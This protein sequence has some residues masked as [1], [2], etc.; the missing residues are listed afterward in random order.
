MLTSP[1]VATDQLLHV[2]GLTFPCSVGMWGCFVLHDAPNAGHAA[3]TRV[4]LMSLSPR[5]EAW[6]QVATCPPCS[7]PHISSDL[8]GP[9]GVT[10]IP[11]QTL[12]DTPVWPALDKGDKTNEVGRLT[13]LAKPQSRPPNSVAAATACCA[14]DTGGQFSRA[15]QKWTGVATGRSVQSH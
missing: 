1:Q 8:S 14:E 4:A 10:L 3:V 12:Q 7:C 11:S 6:L 13:R 9:F 15:Q 2:E 5:T